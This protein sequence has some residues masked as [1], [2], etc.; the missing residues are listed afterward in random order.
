MP[1]ALHAQPFVHFC[2]ACV[3]CQASTYS[4]SP[5]MAEAMHTSGQHARLD[6]NMPSTEV[7]L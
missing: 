5:G 3:H 2:F 4:L 1:G 6:R 7:L